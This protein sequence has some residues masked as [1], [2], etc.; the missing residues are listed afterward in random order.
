[1]SK[2]V[3]ASE[4]FSISS[5]NRG[6]KWP[7]RGPGSR[8]DPICLPHIA[9]GFTLEP[10]E[11][12]FTIGSCFARHIEVALKRQGFVVPAYEFSVPKEEIMAGTNMISGILNKY[13]P[14]SMLNEIKY[15]IGDYSGRQFLVEDANGEYLDEQLH[16][17]IAV[18]LERGLERREQLKKL[19]SDALTNCR[20][21]IITLGLIE[22][23]WDSQENVYLNETPN[24]QL[25][26][27]YP[28][29]FFFEVLSPQ[30]TIDAVD[31]LV[32]LLKTHGRADQRIMMTVSPVPIQRT[33]T[34]EDIISANTYSKAVLRV[35]AKQVTEKYDIVDYYPSFESVTHSDRMLAWEDDLVHVKQ[36]L[37]AANVNRMIEQYSAVK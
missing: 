21:V 23:W 33:F 1:M 31:E 18:S 34:G 30:A 25:I 6:A 3:S 19:Y 9:P 13:T 4:A 8:L 22:A 20:I 2:R 17:N 27:K 11:S 15:A 32:S 16:T 29:R 12:I 37:V 14:H 10:G 35:A 28:E 5:R 36:D 7:G 26:K 24:H